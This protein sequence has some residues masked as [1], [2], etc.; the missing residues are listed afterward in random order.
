MGKGAD[1]RSYK[2]DDAKLNREIERVDK[3]IKAVFTEA[4]KQRSVVK[5]D[6]VD[7]KIPEG[8]FHIDRDGEIW[9]KTKLGLKQLQF[10]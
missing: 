3:R 1:K 6:T 5:R 7:T 8:V 9:I 2:H 4:T 10:V